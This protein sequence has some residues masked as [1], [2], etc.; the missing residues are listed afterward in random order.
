MKDNVLTVLTDEAT[1]ANEIDAE[2]ARAEYAE[3]AARRVT[4]AH[5]VEDRRRQMTRAK[6][7]EHLASSR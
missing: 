4:D 2:A 6:A 7:K 5:G 1:P 3:A